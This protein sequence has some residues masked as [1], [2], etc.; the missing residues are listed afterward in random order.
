[1]HKKYFGLFVLFFIFLMFI[2]CSLISKGKSK[3][4]NQIIID[5]SMPI[6]VSEW[7]RLLKI[8]NDYLD[9]KEYFLTKVIKTPGG[10]AA[11]RYLNDVKKM[12]DKDY[13]KL[14]IEVLYASSEKQMYNF[15]GYFTSYGRMKNIWLS[16]LA[17]PH[18]IIETIN[19]LQENKIADKS[20]ELTKKYLPESSSINST[21]YF[22]VHGDIESP[23]MGMKNGIDLFNLP[24]NEEE[25]IEFD[26][27]INKIS[28]WAFLDSFE[29]LAS[30]IDKDIRLE[31][32]I[33][34]MRILAREGSYAYFFRNTKESFLDN[35]KYYMYDYPEIWEAQ[36]NR[37]PEL[38]ILAD[39]DLKNCLKG[40]LS[41]KEIEIYWRKG[42]VSPAS[43]LGYNMLKKI[44]KYLGIDTAVEAVKDYRKLIF[45]YDRAAK[46]SN[47]QDQDIYMFNKKLVYTIAFYTGKKQ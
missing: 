16:K 25:D 18:T 13:Y 24:V 44:D 11:L 14:I 20:M 29:K 47:S 4:E 1:M 9:V 19:T 12:E 28:G 2:Q 45:Y 41:R 26:K 6:E 43:V 33:F 27:I 21:F 5:Y 23:L 35:E 39:R 32:K 40:E 37:L 15:D 38:Y 31:E 7:L 10:K 42:K 3:P 22:Y 8:D 17:E 30:H 46:A 36:N 34:L